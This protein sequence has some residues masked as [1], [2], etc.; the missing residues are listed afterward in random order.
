MGKFATSQRY[1]IAFVL[2]Y[3]AAY[4]VFHH[5]HV[6]FRP[7]AQQ[8]H[9]VDATP[10]QPSP[11]TPTDPSSLEND[12]APDSSL[13]TASDASSLENDLTPEPSLPA[14][15]EPSPPANE[16]PNIVHF[17][18]LVPEAAESGGEIP[19]L[20][21][22]LSHFIA[23]YSAYHYVKP[24]TIYIHTN[25]DDDIIEAARKTG[26]QFTKAIINLPNVVFRRTEPPTHTSRGVPIQ[27]L[28]H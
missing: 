18:Q 5:F 20:T 6:E 1:L 28:Q 9:E 3:V 25:A 8:S 22:T 26:N 2:V 4:F 23:L 13:P 10:A 16:I 24:Q 12:F 7:N 14:P 21:F 11:P 17:I 15:I 19:A 27:M